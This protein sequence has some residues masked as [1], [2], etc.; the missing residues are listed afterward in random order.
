M[1]NF[2]FFLEI[3]KNTFPF[4]IFKNIYHFKIF[5]S[6]FYTFFFDFLALVIPVVTVDDG[7]RHAPHAADGDNGGGH[8]GGDNKQRC[9]LVHRRGVKGG[10]NHF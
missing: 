3:K 6:Y 9:L 1:N 2:F 5:V 8:G 10:L 4:F 7:G